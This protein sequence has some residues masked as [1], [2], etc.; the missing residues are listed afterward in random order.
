MRKSVI[1]RASALALAALWIPAL[2]RGS[3]FFQ[4]RVLWNASASA[5][6]GLYVLR[7]AAPLRVRELVIVTSPPGLADFMAIRGYLPRHVPLVK[8]VA[9]LPPQT[10]CRTGNAIMVDGHT[11]AHARDRDR[12]NRPLPRWR[13]CRTLRADDVFLL[14][15]APDSFD[16][17]YFGVTR[18]ADAVTAQAIPLWTLEH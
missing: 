14:N 10:V 4:P 18:A 8:T 9:A 12:L 5:P 17:R 11:V 13:G 2:L 6:R 1:L 3:L 15:A 7:D 16:G